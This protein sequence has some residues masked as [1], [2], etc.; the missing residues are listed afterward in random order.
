M[1]ERTVDRLVAPIPEWVVGSIPEVVELGSS[2]WLAARSGLRR[3]GDEVRGERHPIPLRHEKGDQ[4]RRVDARLGVAS[5]DAGVPELDSLVVGGVVNVVR[6]RRRIRNSGSLI[7][8][9]IAGPRRGRAQ[10]AKIG[11]HLRSLMQWHSNALEAAAL[12]PAPQARGK[13][14]ARYD[15][16]ELRRIA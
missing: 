11:R 7:G 16:L 10:N 8:A 6:W 15:D 4:R 9:T 2:A 12:T 3:G 5:C 14:I 13:A 1:T